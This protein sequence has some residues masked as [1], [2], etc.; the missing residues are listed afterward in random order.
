MSKYPVPIDNGGGY[1]VTQEDGIRPLVSI[2][3]N[4]VKIIGNKV[5]ISN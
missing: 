3:M 1:T 4:K 5:K 2:P